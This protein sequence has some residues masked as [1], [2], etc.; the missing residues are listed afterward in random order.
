MN[1]ILLRKHKLN[2]KYH[3]TLSSYINSKSILPTLKAERYWNQAKVL[4][5]AWTSAYTRQEQ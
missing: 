1:T 2:A 3:P 5:A 4:Y